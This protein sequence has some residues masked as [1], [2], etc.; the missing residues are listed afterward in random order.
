[1]KRCPKC[2]NTY[3]EGPRTFYPMS[4]WGHECD[5][6]FHAEEAVIKE[7][8]VVGLTGTVV[9]VHPEGAYTVEINLGS[10]NRVEVVVIDK[11]LVRKIR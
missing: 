2:G 10:P 9:S 1:M 3:G 11:E 8:D 5:H 6:A 4:S 7:H